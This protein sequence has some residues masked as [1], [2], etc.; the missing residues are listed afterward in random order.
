[1]STSEIEISGYRPG[2]IGRVAELHAAYYSWHWDFGL[3]FEAK[4]ARELADFHER[5]D[6]ALDGFWCAHF[7]GCMVGSIT[8]DSGETGDGSAA[9][10]RWFI[11]DEDCQGQG[12]GRRLMTEAMA[13]CDAVGFDRVWLWTFA[14]LD[15]ARRLYQDFGF[16]LCREITADQWGKAVDEQMFERLR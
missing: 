7:E 13:F 15:A 5:F 10:L 11:M 8:I 1:M 3:Y 16:S 14:G 2:A 6:P 4:V 9:H 12:L